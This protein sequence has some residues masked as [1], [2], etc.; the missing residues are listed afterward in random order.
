MKYSTILKAPSDVFIN[1]NEK[2]QTFT[3]KKLEPVNVEH[4]EWKNG[5]NN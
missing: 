2:Q 3:S 5:W 4:F 1:D